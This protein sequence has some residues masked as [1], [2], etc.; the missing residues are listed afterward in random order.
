MEGDLDNLTVKLGG[1][2]IR[3][4]LLKSYQNYACNNVLTA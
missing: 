2:K 1:Q 4:N 3:L